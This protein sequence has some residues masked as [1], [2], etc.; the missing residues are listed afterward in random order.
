[1][2]LEKPDVR[3][4]SSILN[5]CLPDIRLESFC[6]NVRVRPKKINGER[7]IWRILKWIGYT[8]LTEILISFSIHFSFMVFYILTCIGRA[9]VFKISNFGEFSKSE[10]NPPCIQRI[11]LPINP[12]NGI[13][14]NIFVKSSYNLGVPKRLLR[15]S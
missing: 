1:M 7:W 2:A 4:P 5:V 6:V 15:S 13:I 8:M 9:N 14:S 10:D 12:V 11:R 3:F